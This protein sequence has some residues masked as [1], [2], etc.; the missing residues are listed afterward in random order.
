MFLALKHISNNFDNP[1]IVQVIYRAKMQ[2]IL[3]LQ[4]LKCEDQLI[5]SVIYRCTLNIVWF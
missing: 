1:L 3:W 4:L 5:Y 2:N